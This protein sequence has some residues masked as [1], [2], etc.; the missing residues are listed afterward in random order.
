MQ[1]MHQ[2][3]IRMRDLHALGYVHRDLKPGNVMWLPRQTR[4]TIIDFGCAARTGEA[5]RL[6]FSIAYAAPEVINAYRHG[7]RTMVA[8]VPHLLQSLSLNASLSAFS[9]CPTV[10]PVL[11]CPKETRKVCKQGP[12]SCSCDV[13]NSNVAGRGAALFLV[14][15][16]GSVVSTT[17]CFDREVHAGVDGRVVAGSDGVRAPDRKFR[18]AHA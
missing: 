3:A 16:V 7:D 17:A 18:T 2:L 1:M 6:G 8:K 5:A 15:T 12:I 10:Q 13:L 9:G 14:L 4:W 11:P